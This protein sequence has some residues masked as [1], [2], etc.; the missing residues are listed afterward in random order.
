MKVIEE[1]V[2]ISVVLKMSIIS[3]QNIVEKQYHY[4]SGSS[5]C[6]MLIFIQTKGHAVYVCT[7]L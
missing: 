1:T 4:N 6:V 3:L 7:P 2:E 5:I